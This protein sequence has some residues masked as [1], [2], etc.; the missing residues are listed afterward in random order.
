VPA[1]R[2]LA[3]SAVLKL[4]PARERALFPSLGNATLGRRVRRSVKIR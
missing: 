2:D 4:Q 1:E 3:A